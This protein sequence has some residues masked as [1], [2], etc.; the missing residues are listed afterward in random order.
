[1]T[2]GPTWRT[3][4]G[5]G[6]ELGGGIPIKSPPPLTGRTDIEGGGGIIPPVILLLCI[7]LLFCIVVLCVLFV[8]CEL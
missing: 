1:M 4:T 8:Y 7:W 6:I 3:A 2:G 5:G